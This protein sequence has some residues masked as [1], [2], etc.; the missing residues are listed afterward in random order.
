MLVQNLSFDG[1]TIIVPLLLNDTKDCGFGNEAVEWWN[2]VGEC[3]YGSLPYWL[4]ID[5]NQFIS[6]CRNYFIQALGYSQTVLYNF[7]GQSN[8]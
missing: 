5:W 7:V 4:V 6:R 1:E 8:S 2:D 3:G